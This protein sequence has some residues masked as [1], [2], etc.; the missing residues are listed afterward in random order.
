LFDGI[1]GFPLA[2]IRHGIKPVWA[3]EIEPVPI[4]ITKKHFPDM[5][6]LGDA[7]ERN[8]AEIE[9]VD[10]I[11]FGSPCQDLSN[12]GLRAGLEGSR[13]GLFFEAVRIIKQ[14]REKTNGKY[15]K[16]IIWE[17]VTGAFSSTEGKDFLI[18]L[19]E[20]TSIAEPG[21][22]ISEPPH[23]FE[24][25]IGWLAAG[26]IVGDDY[27]L[28]WRTLDAQYWGVPQRR[29]RIFLIADFG[30]ECAG[31]ILF[32][33]DSLSGDFEESEEA[34]EGTPGDIK[35]GIRAS[36]FDGWRSVTGSIGYKEEQSP[37]MN[38][39]M[40][41]DVVIGVDGLNQN[42]TGDKT[43]AIRGQRSDG[44]NVGMIIFNDKGE[45]NVNVSPCLKT[46]GYQQYAVDFGRVADRIQ[47][48]A[49]KAVT[50]QAEGGGA[51]AKTGLYYLPVAVHQNQQGEVRAD[52]VANTLSTNANA[53]GRNAPLIACI[54]NGQANSL[55][56]SD[57]VGSLNC[58]NDQQAIM[59]S[60]GF[61]CRNHVANEELSSTL[62]SKENGGNSLNYI[63]PVMVS[64]KCIY[65][66]R[67]LTPL[68]C[69]RL[70]GFPDYWTEYG[71]EGRKISDNAR[72]K[73]LGNSL[74]MPCIDFLMRRIKR[75]AE[76]KQG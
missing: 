6:H 17:N 68:E 31:E 60:V 47:M 65:K 71:Y 15:P 25:P 40:P 74:A 10:I 46:E 16:R 61:D 8:G 34:R 38:M 23:K 57:K 41:P 63:N 36:G 9:P 26:A 1:G 50:L 29:Q 59:Y 67:R 49:D 33:P 76:G 14:M 44:D 27:S 73:C 20:I 52:E 72:Y 32:K 4:S 62:Q 75:F 3:S 51:G 58:M 45:N 11:T 18:V 28:A 55:E 54:G 64:E 39:K 21:I 35:N 12:A 69:E 53:S 37:C 70:Q 19:Q 30:S 7:K 2:A 5:E 48:N 13:S 24:E 43:T 56:L 42:L 22:S 66:V